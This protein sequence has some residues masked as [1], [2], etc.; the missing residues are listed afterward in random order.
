MPLTSEQ[1]LSSPHYQALLARD[2]LIYNALYDADLLTFQ[3]NDGIMEDSLRDS[4]DS[5]QLYENVFTGE[6]K[7]STNQILR[8]TWRKSIQM[9]L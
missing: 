4:N 3:N 6:A 5:M 8:S 7:N 1:L 9:N 2:E